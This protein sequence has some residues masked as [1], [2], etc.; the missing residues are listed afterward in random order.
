MRR[1][2][3]IKFSL[4]VRFSLISFLLLTG[5]STAMTIVIQRQLE[6][7]ALRL[8]AD[9]AANHLTS[10]LTHDLSAA[11]MA[12]PLDP[13]RYAQVDALI[14]EHVLAIPHIVRVKI[15]RSDGVVVYSDAEEIVGQRFPLTDELEEALAGEVVTELSDLNQKENVIE[16][17]HFDQLFEVYVPL[18]LAG[19]SEIVGAYEIYHDL[20]ALALQLS[21]MRRAVRTV[22]G[23]GFLILYLSLF[24]LVRTA[25]R[26]LVHRNKENVRLYGQAKQ[27]IAELEQADK[28]LERNYQT[29]ATLSALLR[30]A[31]LNVPLEEQLQL[32]LDRVI[33][34]P[35]LALEEQGAIFLVKEDPEM[36]VMQVQKGLS[37]SLLTTCARV[38]FG[39]CLCGRAALSGNIEFADR[40]DDRHEILPEGFSPH[41]HYCVPVQSADRAG[42]FSST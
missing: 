34:V 26:E 32:S 12:I 39:R 41:G 31:L 3:S 28:E 25:S 11:D 38:P 10:M 16:Q 18:Q 36:L 15:W 4:L 30:T 19:S 21:A 29:Q 35:Q 6:Q 27:Q 1:L 14:R 7:A 23:L 9:L 24:T 42:L 22:T 37:S 33:S 8:V 17:G 20:T 40:V 2:L 13:D 5:I